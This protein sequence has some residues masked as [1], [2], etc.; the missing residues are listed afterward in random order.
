MS[1]D[2]DLHGVSIP[3]IQ[4]IE[5]NILSF[6]V[7]NEG[8]TACNTEVKLLLQM[9]KKPRKSSFRDKNLF[10]AQGGCGLHMA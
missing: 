1:E 2:A 4:E 8:L 6:G 9:K 10:T 7:F 5:M 3:L